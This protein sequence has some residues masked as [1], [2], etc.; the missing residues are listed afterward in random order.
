MES[1][2]GG[3]FRVALHRAMGCYFARV[4]EIPGCVGRGST[5]VEA[6]ETARSA[7]RAYLVMAR[8]LDGDTA[9]VQLEIRV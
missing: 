5:Q 9:V 3:S 8:A 4:L 6:V 2:V 1:D 7:I